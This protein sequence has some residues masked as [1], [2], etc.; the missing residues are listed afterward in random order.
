MQDCYTT[1]GKQLRTMQS[2]IGRCKWD[3]TPVDIGQL[4]LDDK[5]LIRFYGIADVA[6][7]IL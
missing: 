3:D 1:N 2:N 5:R 6:C 4:I 7:F